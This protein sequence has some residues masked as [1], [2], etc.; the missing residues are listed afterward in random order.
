MYMYLPCVSTDVPM[1][2]TGS[3]RT[4]LIPDAV[5]MYVTLPH[6]YSVSRASCWPVRLPVPDDNVHV[7][8]YMY[9]L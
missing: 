7:Y 6:L 4:G 1:E 8:T 3:D 9:A 5:M 2:W